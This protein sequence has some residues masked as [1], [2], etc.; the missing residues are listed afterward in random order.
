MAIARF[1]S[2]RGEKSSLILVKANQF[3]F[4]WNCAYVPRA[5]VAGMEQG[6]EFHIP[7]GYKLVPILSEDGTPR[8]TKD[9]EPLHQLA[10]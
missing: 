4:G 6:Q 10:Y 7:D 5:A 3:V 1:H 8:V 9:G 2:D